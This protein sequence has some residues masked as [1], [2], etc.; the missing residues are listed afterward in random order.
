MRA[1][2]LTLDAAA[3]DDWR[4]DAACRGSDP[5]M[6][7]PHNGYSETHPDVLAAKATCRAC[8]VKTAC[9]QWALD[10]RDDHAVLG[11]LTAHERRS[12]VRRIRRGR[13]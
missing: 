8:P 12:L 7:F 11:G 5:E 9:L 6:F 1:P 13:A 3:T 10:V 4:H 2:R